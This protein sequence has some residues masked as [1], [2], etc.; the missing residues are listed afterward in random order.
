MTI[1]AHLIACWL[2]GSPALAD[3]PVSG[4]TGDALAHG[5]LRLHPGNSRY[6]TDG[7]TLPDGS[8]KAVYLTG[9]HTWPNLIDRGPSDPP[10]LFDF[11]GYLDFLQRDDHNFIRLWSRHVTWY[12]GYG[13]GELR[14]S[15]LAWERTGPGN[16]LDGKPGFDL[17][18][19]HQPYFDRLR[20]RVSTARD[21]GIYVGVMLF[22][23]NYECTGGWRGNPFHARNNVN[24]F[25]GDPAAQGQGLKTHTLEVPAINRLQE[26]YVRKVID[27]LNDLD[28]VLYEISNE[29]HG[30]SAEW[31]KHWI[32]FIKEYQSD[33]P[34]QHPVGMTA[35]YLDRPEDN[36][37]LLRA[38]DADW[39]SP[40]T[41]AAGVRNI[42]AADGSKVSILDSDHWFVKE[43][44]DDPAFGR[45]WVWKAFCRG[46]NPILMEHLPPL[47]FVDPDYPLSIGDPGYTASRRAMGQTRRLAERLNLARMLPRNDL[48]STGFCLANPGNEYVVYQPV[49]G[50]AFSVEITKGTYQFEWFD[51]DKGA[52]AGNGQIEAQGGAQE[53]KSPFT[54]DAVLYLKKID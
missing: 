52:A 18:K 40:L 26:A 10:P 41:D 23:G 25:D 15:P 16:A 42:A 9:S 48:S 46:H 24:G 17:T 45:E 34:S 28:N 53:F 27:T 6:F 50:A 47:S 7:T 19:F 4:I 8:L 38:S 21:R 11:E 2:L 33:K 35:L 20:A 43:L 5:P 37:A 14:A 22:G 36:D 39:I 29:G 13:E 51:P 32:R 30:S 49:R 12:D 54:S 1:P 3:S 31:Q 44:Y